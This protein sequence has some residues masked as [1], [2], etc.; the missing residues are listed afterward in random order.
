ML[1]NIDGAACGA[2]VFGVAEFAVENKVEG[3]AAFDVFAAD[4]PK[5]NLG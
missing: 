5:L 3:F 4:G 1:P 2:V